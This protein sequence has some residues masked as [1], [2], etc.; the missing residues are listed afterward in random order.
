MRD[1]SKLIEVVQ[2][3]ISE[4][5]RSSIVE[6][7]KP[8]I[9]L[10]TNGLE[11]SEVGITKLGGRPDLSDGINW[12]KSI[13]DNNYLSFLGQVNLEEIQEYDEFGLLPKKGI[14]YFFFNLNSGDDGRL[15]FTT[16]VENL[17]RV[18]TP[19]ELLEQKKSFWN[20][21]LTGKTKKRELDESKVEIFK[22][23][24]FPSW[25]SIWAEKIKQETGTDIEPSNAFEEGIFEERYDE[26]ESEST[27]NHHLLGY[28]IG[29][30]NEYHEMTFVDY[31]KSNF[32][33]MTMKEI[34]EAL[35][36]KL[37]FQFDSDKN[38]NVGIGDWGKVYFFIHEDDL[39]SHNFNNIKISSDCY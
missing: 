21:I 4:P 11:C 7:I 20:R 9:R 23:Y 16:D 28:Y 6:N 34:N 39:K 27:S 3:H 26:G 36:W 38:L 24:G 5:Y 33:N 14:F 29:I 2:K 32:E 15:I 37:L 25:D 1:K 18:E 17:K 30:Q 22:E 31:E 8:S 10:K 19:I 13:Y 35:Q 12:P